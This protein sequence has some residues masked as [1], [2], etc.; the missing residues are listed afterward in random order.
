MIKLV[1]YPGVYYR[2][3]NQKIVID[4]SVAEFRGP[5]KVEALL[6]SIKLDVREMLPNNPGNSVDFLNH[7]LVLP[8]LYEK[9]YKGNQAIDLLPETVELIKKT[10]KLRSKSPEKLGPRER[11]KIKMLNRLIL[12]Q[13]YKDLCPK[14]KQS[15]HDKSDRCFYVTY[16]HGARKVWEKVGWLS[17]GYSAQVASSI[18]AERIRSVRHGDELPKKK[19]NMITFGEVWVRYDKWLDT[20]EKVAIDDRSRYKHH[21]RQRFE[22][23]PLSFITPDILD[24]LKGDLM[25]AG[26]APATVKHVLALVRQIYNKAIKWRLWEGVNPVRDVEMPRLNNRRVRFLSFEEA[27]KLLEELGKKSNQLREMALLSLYTGMRAGEIFKLREQD[28]NCDNETIYI[29]DPKNN[30]ARH[31]YMTPSVKSML[32]A[33]LSGNPENFVFKARKGGAIKE[34][35]NA[36]EKIVEALGFNAGITDTRQKVSF[37]TLRHTFASWLAMNG[38]PLLT[39]KELLGHKS[40][41]MTERYAHLMPDQ[42]RSAIGDIEEMLKKKKNT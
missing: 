32:K 7:L 18:R 19:K 30:T 11:I 22:N 12:E 8:D 20:G 2:E 35:S 1:K 13:A 41:T 40:I 24:G 17:E 36:F 6:D 26:L 39:I 31:T 42:K 21:L 25:K 15:I 16:R 14:L 34:I 3:S 10:A 33:K 23:K 37:H 5:Y 29:S 27:R 4:F 9:A 28:I 38:T